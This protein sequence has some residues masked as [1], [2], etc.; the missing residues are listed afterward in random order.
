MQLKMLVVGLVIVLVLLVRNKVVYFLL[1][2][3]L[4][5]CYHQTMFKVAYFCLILML[6]FKNI[7]VTVF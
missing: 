4:V 1:T 3:T 5:I 7:A 6:P 2:V